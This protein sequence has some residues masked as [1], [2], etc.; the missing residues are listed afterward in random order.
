MFT[1]H[2]YKAA[3]AVLTE[4]ISVAKT[5]L[6]VKEV[7]ISQL[8]RDKTCVDMF[9]VL[10]YFSCLWMCSYVCFSHT[11]KAQE[12]NM[13]MLDIILNRNIRLIDY[14]VMADR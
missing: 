2:E 9:L 7:P 8:E 11:I 5:I 14:E 1:D 6:G 12:Y 10:C 13:D 3:G 4:D